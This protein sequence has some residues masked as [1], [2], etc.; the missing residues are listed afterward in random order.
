MTFE[1]LKEA[2]FVE[3]RRCTICGVS[4]RY[5]LHPE[6]AA[7]VFNSA[8]GCG[9]PSETYRV[10]TNSELEAIPLPS[11]PERQVI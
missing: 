2:G 6:Y 11:P 3:A 10:I 8:C 5:S 1:D 4:L 7:A 9:G